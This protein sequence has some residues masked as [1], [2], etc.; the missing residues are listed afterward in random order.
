[1]TIQTI[2]IIGGGQLARMLALAGIPLGYKFIFLDTYAECPAGDLGEVIIA[3]YDDQVKLLE[4]ASRCDVLTFDFENVPATALNKIVKQ[5]D[6]H[7]SSNAL[8]TAQDRLSEKTL[9]DELGIPTPDFLNIESKQDIDKAKD[10]PF[11]AILKTRR[12]GYDGKGQVRI[13]SHTELMAAWNELGNTECLLEGFVQ[14]DFEV[15]QIAV[16]DTD[17]NIKFYPLT[18]NRHQ[19]GILVESNAP[20]ENIKLEKLAQSHTKKLL[21]K[22][23]YV[24][25]LAI[26]FF[27]NGNSLIINEM[28]PRVHNSGHWTIEGTLSSQFENHI[29]AITGLPLGDTA[30]IC[31][32]KM[33]NCLGEMPSRKESLKDFSA[34]YHD[35]AK[36]ARPGR[37]V[38]HITYLSKL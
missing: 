28:A 2:G 27:V 3:Q 33:V 23:N 18:E 26:E 10:F 16:R 11:P 9:F 24:G 5:V 36:A 19:N 37:K 8:K 6:F 25:I 34:H 14:F 38:G 7:P 15:S 35:Y 22:F 31:K 17:G 13:S 30:A 21:E 20:Y 29:R 32:T 4:L 1:V 12:L